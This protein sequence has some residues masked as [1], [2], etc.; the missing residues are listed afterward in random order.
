M[1]RLNN[2]A[3][4]QMQG[5]N[6]NTALAALSR[7]YN[8]TR[9]SSPAVHCNYAIALTNFGRYAE[10]SQIL[11]KLVER[12]RDDLAAW[13]AYGVLCLV[14]AQPDYAAKCFEEC[15]RLD[16]ENGSLVFD[17]SLALMQAGNWK[18]GL[19]LYDVRRTHKPERMFAG[20]PNW[21]GSRDKAVYVWAEQGIGDTLQFSRY[22]PWLKSLSRRVVFALPTSLHKLFESFDVEL[23][24][25][26][27]DVAGIDCAVPLMS[28]AKHY[29]EQSGGGFMQDPGLIGK[30]IVA[31]EFE[32][33]SPL[34]V[35]VCWACN[36]SSGHFNER[37]VPFKDI[38][39]LAG[40]PW[41]DLIS[42]Q[43]GDAAADIATNNAQL[44]VQDMTPYLT[45]QWEATVAVIKALDYVVATDTSVAHLAGLLGKPTIMFLARRDWWRWGNSGDTTFWY[46]SMTI[47]RQ[48]TPFSWQAEVKKASSILEKAAQDRCAT[49]DAA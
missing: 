22:I 20:L 46:P 33:Y 6:R 15:V 28:L 8:N 44:L 30:Y 34:K 21:D 14:S 10:A 5:K 13:H 39:A 38:I 49:A 42:L 29:Y 45:D 36:P 26:T 1:S 48:E 31:R 11:L 43:V 16:P 40:L 9:E 7:L 3:A 4:A 35:G 24:D 12:N 41:V 17:L 37:S 2:L 32:Y 27:T 23:V 18:D 25:M 19:T 47:I